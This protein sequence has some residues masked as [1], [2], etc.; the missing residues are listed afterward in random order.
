MTLLEIGLIG[1][2]IGGLAGGALAARKAG[3]VMQGRIQ[4]RDAHALELAQ[5]NEALRSKLFAY[6][7]TLIC[8]T[9]GVGKRI[10]E[11][12]EITEALSKHAPDVFKAEPGLIYWLGATDQFLVELNDSLGDPLQD[13]LAAIRSQ[14][15]YLAIH[16]HNDIPLPVS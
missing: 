16:E 11:C 14:A 8:T 13:R 9:G 2:L 4:A 7:D 6:Q 1:A 3:K 10:S 15:I 12:R 5:E